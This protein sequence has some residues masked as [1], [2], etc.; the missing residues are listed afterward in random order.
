VAEPHGVVR[1]PPGRPIWGWL[2][3]PQW[4]R[5]WFSRPLGQT[6]KNKVLS[7]WPKGRPN[8]PLGHWGW[9]G[10]SG[11]AEPPRWPLGVVRPH[12]DGQPGCGRTTPGQT[13]WLATTYGVVQPPQHIF[14]FFLFF[15]KKK[16]VMGA[17]WE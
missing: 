9:F 14:L 13:G 6:P 15:I 10:L 5:G 4:P 17:F 1:P 7:D 11:A 8:H 2:N 12:P 16:N 3:H